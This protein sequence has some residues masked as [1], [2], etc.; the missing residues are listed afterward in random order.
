[1][2][3]KKVSVKVKALTII[4]YAYEAQDAMINNKDKYEQKSVRKM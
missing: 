3:V 1:M 2:N 4:R